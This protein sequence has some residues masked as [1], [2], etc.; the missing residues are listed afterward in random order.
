MALRV[1]YLVGLVTAVL[2]Q[3][4][5]PDFDFRAA[6]KSISAEL[7]SPTFVPYSR[8]AQR[9]EEFIAAGDSYTAGTGCNGNN[10][11]IAGDAVRGKRSYPM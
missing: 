6:A 5:P 8:P 4:I 3:D 7:N 2:G 11:I 10:E 9:V 1:F